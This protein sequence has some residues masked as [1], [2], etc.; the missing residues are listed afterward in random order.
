M[1]RVKQ[2]LALTCV[3]AFLT[4]PSAAQSCGSIYTYADMWIDENSTAVAVSYT[5]GDAFCDDYS[6]YT[7][8]TISMP[9]GLSYYGSGSGLSSFAEAVALAAAAG[10]NGNG[11]VDAYGEVDYVCGG[12]VTSILPSPIS[13]G[14][15]YTKE[16]WIGGQL[17]GMCAASIACSNTT[18]PM[19][20]T[21]GIAVNESNTC[22]PAW[23]IYYLTY[24]VGIFGSWHCVPIGMALRTS[25]TTPEW[26]TPAY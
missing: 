10:E 1:N 2:L 20:Y 24:K 9:S 17:L 22:S 26:C 5:E 18:T 13:I 7:T 16:V 14:G 11:E 25:D 21:P 8:V 23:N 6:A 12:S 19:C 15:A 4:L 3:V